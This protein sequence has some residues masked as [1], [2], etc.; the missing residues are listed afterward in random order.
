MSVP[1]VEIKKWD[2]PDETCAAQTTRDYAGSRAES[3]IGFDPDGIFVP[4][5]PPLPFN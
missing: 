1:N 2:L 4:L 3:G 5:A